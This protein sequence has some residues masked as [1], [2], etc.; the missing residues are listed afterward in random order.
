MRLRTL[1]CAAAATA[2]GALA[3]AALAQ[4][5]E[6]AGPPGPQVYRLDSSPPDISGVWATILVVRPDRS[7][8]FVDAP[9]SAAGQRIVD[10]VRGQ[11]DLTG[12]EPNAHCVEPGMPTMMFGYGGAPLEI[13]Q[14]PDRVTIL[15]EVAMQVRRVYMDGRGHPESYPHT[16]SGHSVARWEGDT[17]VVDTAL[18]TEWYLRRWPHSEDARITER[19]RLVRREEADLTGAFPGWRPAEFSDVLLVDEITLT[20]PALYDAPQTILVYFSALADDAIL[21]DN[22]PEGLWWEVMETL[23]VD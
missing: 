13:L 17:L 21:E 3:A 8:G 10:D 5:A 9:L 23:R 12:M 11:Y 20:D 18:L 15:T 6:Q 19:F 2:L 16:R 4:P 22:C 7:S 14:E 1:M